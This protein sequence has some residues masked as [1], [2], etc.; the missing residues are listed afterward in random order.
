MHTARVM[1][2]AWSPNSQFLVS[3]SIDTNVFIWKL[4]KPNERPTMIKGEMNLL[5]K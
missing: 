1:C 3:G 4:A 2:I 5:T